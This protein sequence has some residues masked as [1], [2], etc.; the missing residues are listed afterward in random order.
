MNV[1]RMITHHK[2]RPGAI[3]W[4]KQNGRIAIGWGRTGDIRKYH[5]EA[6]I[7]A[8]IRD[9]YPQL[10]N[11]HFGAP[12][13]WDFCHEIQI[14]DLVILAGRN[15]RELVVKITGNYEFV[16]EEVPILGDYQN[17]RSVEIMQLDGNELWHQAGKAPGQPVY[18]TLIKCAHQVDGSE[19]NV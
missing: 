2:D 3:A 10:R 12:S 8:A 19:L 13:L 5:S 11:A 18:R 16:A 17:Q 15:P 14:G 4:T 1:W 9:C 7:K 6:E